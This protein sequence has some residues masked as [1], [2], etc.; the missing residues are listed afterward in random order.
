MPEIKNDILNCRILIVEDDRLGRLVLHEVFK[1]QGFLHIEEV[2]NGRLA[3]EIMP[4]FKPNL[5]IL[6]VVMPEMDGIECCKHMRAHSDPAIANVPILFQTALDSIADKARLFAAGATDYLTKPID[7]HEIT[8]RAVVHLEREVM[9]R[10]LREYNQR[11]KRELDTARSTQHLMLP[12]PRQLSNI[13]ALHHV[14]L[15]HHF[16]P[17]SE[18]GGD[19]WGIKSISSEEF[20]IS[21]VDFSGHGVNAALNVFRLQALIHSAPHLDTAPSAYLTNLNTLLAQLVPVGQFA[22][23]FYGVVNTVSNTLSYASAAAPAPILFHSDG[24]YSALDSSGMLL[25]AMQNTTYETRIVP[26]HS[27]D[28]LLLYSDA[29]TETRDASGNVLDA[30]AIAVMFN[31]AMRAMPGD[32]SDYFQAICSDFASNFSATLN[33]DL[34]IVGCTRA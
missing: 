25:G 4:V 21:T 13:E 30:D 11:V 17:S 6:D 8:A 29:L 22:T 27:G 10:R 3:L 20:S 31:D 34:T 23:M 2:E 26:F 12:S 15:H 32:Y 9:M 16:Q 19:L 33:D 24:R 5:V 14:H 7:P 1:Q 28:T 18:L